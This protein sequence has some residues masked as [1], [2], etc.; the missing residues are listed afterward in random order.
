MEKG[1]GGLEYDDE[2][3]DEYSD[4]RKGRSGS[5]SR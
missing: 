4:G 2:D 5:R 3:E 1:G